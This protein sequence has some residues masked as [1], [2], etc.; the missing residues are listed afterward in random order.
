[1]CKGRLICQAVKIGLNHKWIIVKSICDLTCGILA[2]PE[3]EPKTPLA[4]RLRDVRR[5]LGDPDRDVFAAELN[6][7]KSSIAHYERGERT[8][9]AE[10][11]AAYNAKHAINMNW[12]ITGEGDMFSSPA[13]ALN[14]ASEMRVNIMRLLTRLVMRLHQDAGIKLPAEEVTA[15]TTVLYNELSKRVDDLTDQEEV[16]AVL[17]QLEVRLK[18]RLAEAKAQPGSGKLEVS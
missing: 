15:E 1:M 18:K 3:I 2:R 7:S 10:V 8:P 16:E 17:P 5:R 11:L 9:D 13:S 14:Y 6:I 12:L 4:A